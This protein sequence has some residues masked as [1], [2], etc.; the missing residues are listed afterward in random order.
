MLSDHKKIISCYLLGIA[1]ILLSLLFLIIGYCFFFGFTQ[2]LFILLIN[3]PFWFFLFK[4]LLPAQLERTK[5]ILS[6]LWAILILN[7]FLA[8]L[9]FYFLSL[10][11]PVAYSAYLFFMIAYP[12]GIVLLFAL[13]SIVRWYLA[14]VSEHSNLAYCVLLVGS[15]RECEKLKRELGEF[16]S[17]GIQIV[18]YLSW[19]NKTENP[20]ANLNCLGNVSELRKVL[21]S[22]VIDCIFVVSPPSS[23][24]EL[25]FLFRRSKIEGLDFV[26]PVDLKGELQATTGELFVLSGEQ[27]LFYKGISYPGNWFC[28]K[29]FLDFIFSFLLIL[30]L[31]PAW[32]V[33]PLLVKLDS[34]GS[35]FFKQQRIGRH[36]R[37]FTLYKF[38]SMIQGAERLQ[39]SLAHLN[40]M[41]GP[42]FKIR[43]DPRVTRV[44]RFLRRTSLDELPQL[45]NVLTGDISLV[46]PRPPVPGE[47]LQYKPW[48]RKKLAVIQGITC[49]W[50]ISGR[51]DIKFD[52]WM[53]LD[54][55]YIE[56]WNFW[57]DIQ[58]LF[59]T[60]PAVFLK[61]GAR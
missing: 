13:G 48:E 2:A 7:Y 29:R 58:I 4:T 39:D 27:F 52:E 59:K 53:K 54:V 16:R 11:W 21:H 3:F 17:L 46:G 24:Q 49:L 43:N 18:G 35:A 31:F 20:K 19:T 56:T 14:R 51:N 30:F 57:L 32:V 33:I 22:S 45:F 9:F 37:K 6:R 34:K 5:K 55:L 60:I 40:E 15:V 61:R 26:C 10:F 1:L 50:Q 36:G 44:G 23:F 42:A 38:R 28:L 12:L 47:V 25:R 41:D 8:L